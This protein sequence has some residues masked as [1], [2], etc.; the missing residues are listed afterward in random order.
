MFDE[1]VQI[2]NVA[3]NNLVD[4]GVVLH[5]HATTL[6]AL[7]QALKPIAE[8]LGPNPFANSGEPSSE[9][10]ER[11]LIE[12]VSRLVQALD[13]F[14]KLIGPTWRD[15]GIEQKTWDSLVERYS[16]LLYHRQ[17]V[18]LVAFRP[19][20]LRQTARR[21][22][23]LLETLSG[24]DLPD[25][26]IIQLTRYAEKIERIVCLYD[27]GLVKSR[28]I[29]MDLQVQTLRDYLTASARPKEPRREVRIRALLS[30]VMRNLEPYSTEKRVNLRLVPG[31]VNAVVVVVESDIRRALMNIVHNAIKYSFQMR[32]NNIAW[33]EIRHFI[34]GSYG[35]VE[36]ESWGVPIRPDEIET[37]LI[38]QM[39]Y[40][41]TMSGD[42]GRLGTG[43]GLHDA[44]Q[45]V[46]AHDGELIVESKPSRESDS[47]P[48]NRPFIT[49]VTMKL[50]FSQDVTGD[51]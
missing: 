15:K 35:V 2:E 36:I 38:F 30:E 43:I 37:G 17:R 7:L 6:V 23:V 27:L 14:I 21:L 10:V 31:P 19:P 29:S 49:T 12:P 20:F 13:S 28:I 51:G 9:D 40:R 45:T 26:E 34:D 50:P 5:E 8:S 39:G 32:G 48:Y 3:T 41:G 4:I 25:E 42:R 22:I 33:I 16:Q 11:V 46:T 47:D 44:K 1:Q 24:H 18:K